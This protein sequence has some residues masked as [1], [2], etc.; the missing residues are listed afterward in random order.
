[1]SLQLSLS[2]IMPAAFCRPVYKLNKWLHKTSGATKETL[3]GAGKKKRQGRPR[4]A[5]TIPVEFDPQQLQRKRNFKS[6]FWFS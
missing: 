4:P 2:I 3:S 6:F 5:L 1:M